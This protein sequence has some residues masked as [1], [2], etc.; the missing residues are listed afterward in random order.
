MSVVHIRKLFFCQLCDSKIVGRSFDKSNI[1]EIIKTL[2]KSKEINDFSMD[3]RETHAEKVCNSC[4]KKCNWIKT[5]YKEH[6]TKLRKRGQS[7]IE[8]PFVTTA[9]IPENI[10][11]CHICSNDAFCVICTV[12]MEAVIIVEPSPSKNF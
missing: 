11:N 8:F 9:E 6:L 5:K 1:E 2:Y 10:D 7:E 12:D 4:Y 3:T